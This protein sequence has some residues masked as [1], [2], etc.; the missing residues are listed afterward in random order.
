LATSGFVADREISKKI[1]QICPK[2]DCIFCLILLLL[3]VKTEWREIKMKSYFAF[4]IAGLLF[5][6]GCAPRF[7]TRRNID[8][9]P[10]NSVRESMERIQALER[11]NRDYRLS[12]LFRPISAYI[13]APYQMGGDTR[14][15]MDCSGFV[16]RVFQESFELELPRNASEQFRQSKKINSSEL[17]LGDLV[18]F[19]TNGNGSIGHVGIYLG[20]NFFAHASISAGVVVTSLAEEYYQSRYVSAGRILE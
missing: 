20:D 6:S 8:R 15:G 4:L 14:R 19:D 18:F 1:I 16:Y 5:Y 12:R 17:K 3:M 2:K 11:S 9:Y 7:A 10:H 13:G